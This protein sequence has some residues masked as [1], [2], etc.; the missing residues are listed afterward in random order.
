MLTDALN[1]TRVTFNGNE[2]ALQND[3]GN[4]RITYRNDDG[5]T[6]YA[7][8]SDGMIPLCAKTFG[9][10][11]YVVSTSRDGVGEIGSFPSPDYTNNTGVLVNKYQPLMVGVDADGNIQ[12]LRT[13]GF[14]FSLQHPVEM[15]VESSYDGSVNLILTDNCNKPRIINTGF[16]V[17]E[18]DTYMITER[19]GENN[20]NRYP[21]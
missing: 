18:N 20:T 6:G 3:M 2:T 8:L 13:S 21:V 17:R 5:T 16:A 4:A 1:A 10:V 12:Q 19:F 11:M 15:N 7:Q 14:N 9:R